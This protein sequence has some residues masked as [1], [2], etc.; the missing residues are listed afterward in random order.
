METTPPE[1]ES[2][3]LAE[4]PV[5]GI[6]PVR[7]SIILPS[8]A[9]PSALA[10]YMHRLEQQN[11]GRDCE[12]TT[13]TQGTAVRGKYLLFVRDL[14]D[15][16]AAMLDESIRELETSGNELSISQTG[17][18]VLV[19]RSLYQRVGRL[20]ALLDRARSAPGPGEPAPPRSVHRVKNLNNECLDFACGPDTSIDPDVVIDSPE[21]VRIGAHCVVRKGVVLR[22]EGGEIVIGDH[23]VI[24]HYSIF[25]GKGGIYIGD[26]TVIAPHCG[27]YAQNHTFDRFDVPITKQPNVGQ[28][29]YLMG[30]NWIGAGA[31]VCDDVTL[32]KGAVIGANAT[33]TKSVPMAAVA[34]GSP[35]RVI[36]TRYGPDW[37]FQ[38]RERAACEGM[39]QEIHEYVEERGRRIAE[40]L[41]PQ[42]VVLDIGCGEGIV[43]SLLA[44]TGARVM[45]CDY[46]L[47]VVETAARQFSNI[48][49]VYC[50][51]T[52][53]RFEDGSF[54]TVVLSEVAEHLLRVQLEKTLREACRVLQPQGALLLAT[55][56][57]GKGAC[58]ST[59]AHIYEYSQDEMRALLDQTFDEVRLLDN[60]FGLFVARKR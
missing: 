6:R 31:V 28:G 21:R 40:L 18:F 46:S 2:V 16:D 41:H 51:S 4:P 23:C 43:T 15:F 55:P 52:C 27:F 25:H 12:V 50:N 26:W 19:E 3:A 34:V 22:P 29:I 48:Q 5:P 58:T 42:D 9:E 38:Q 13:D 11:T 30:D 49:F 36:H 57:T 44:Q 60:R 59:Y 10:A 32:G 37:D 7:C 14:V 53:L 33:V 20:E 1:Y 45:G 39:P 56:L 17:K 47:E 35:A 54:T 24:N 8:S